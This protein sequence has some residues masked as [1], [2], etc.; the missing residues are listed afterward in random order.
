[1]DEQK[2]KAAL[3]KIDIPA[4]DENARKRTVNLALAE[5]EA[6]QKKNKNSSQGFPFL[7]RLMGINNPNTG[8][9]TM[10]QKSKKKFI[11]GGMA[12]AMAVVLI[13]GTTVMQTQE[14]LQERQ[15]AQS[16]GKNFGRIAYNITPSKGPITMMA[17]G[18]ADM[19]ESESAASEASSTADLAPI[20]RMEATN[21]LTKAAPQ[22]ANRM[23][24]AESE[25][26][27]VSGAAG[28]AGD[29]AVASAPMIAP[30]PMPPYDM[31]Q[32]Y[33][34][35]QGRDQFE[36]VEINPVKMTAEEPVSTFSADVDTASY[37]FMRRQI[38]NGQLPSADSIRIEELINY[39]D[40]NYALPESRDVPFKPSV[41]I[42]PSP[43]AKGKELVQIGIKGF[44]IE[45]A[46][47]K[48]NLVFLL[49]TSGSMNAPDKLPLLKNSLK[50]VLDTLKPDD[51]IAIAAYAG[52]AGTILEPTKVSDKAKII[53][54][55]DNLQAGGGTAGAAGIE[56][57]Y[58]LAQQ[59]FDKDAVN[60]IILATDGDFNVGIN[61]PKA[62]EEYVAKKRESGVFLSVL[63]FGQ[64]NYNDHLMQ[65]LAQNGNGIAAYIDTLSEARKVLVEEASSS[66]FPIANDV[67]IQVEFNP[68][69]VAEYRLLGYETRAL[70]REDFNNDKVDA[71]D[72]G[73]GHTV[74]AIY[75]VAL[76]GSGALSVDPLR[77]GSAAKPQAENATAN[78]NFGGEYGFLKLRYKLPGEAESKLITTPITADLKNEG[79]EDTKFATAVAGF[80]QLL[81]GGKY[82]GTYS[83]DDVINMAVQSKGA[84]EYGYR[85]EFINLVR[86]AKSL[87]DNK[88]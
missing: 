48:S 63:G 53:A 32:D 50:L 22:A 2:I 25:G 12:T 80:G 51:T 1:M 76:V 30:A 29:M 4:P 56:L 9:D 41:T 7:S 71:G 70:N 47:P 15:N 87:D 24:M 19:V 43:W 13:A 3:H 21:E 17:E 62:L 36:A 57:A 84:D 83:Y 35:D 45:G 65:S 33:Y 16:S 60:R 67:K 26:L 34:Q 61:D 14:I 40:Y 82:T 10:E 38:N 39:F 69:T 28:Y 73:A 5:F 11:Y 85:G 79:N 52:S 86:L 18:L 81:K 54:A 37:A 49:D 8:R 20:T 44:D 46:Q 6:Q 88:Q 27:A 23:M 78:T 68:E 58:S 72:I 55:L 59:N 77:Y 42:T 74:T 31:P 75:E 66:L 64:G